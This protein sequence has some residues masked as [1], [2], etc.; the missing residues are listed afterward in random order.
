MVRPRTHVSWLARLPK[1]VVKQK[2]KKRISNCFISSLQK[3][4][5]DTDYSDHHTIDT[6]HNIVDKKRTVR[7]IG[8]PCNE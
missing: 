1:I 8:M 3:Y 4:I 2:I 6:D 7:S 5:V